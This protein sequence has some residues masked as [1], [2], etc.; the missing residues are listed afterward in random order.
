MEQAL[1]AVAMVVDGGEGGKI[2]VQMETWAQP[3]NKN[4][5]RKM[6]QIKMRYPWGLLSAIG[7]AVP[8]IFNAGEKKYTWCSNNAYLLN[9]SMKGVFVPVLL[10]EIRDIFIIHIQCGA[11]CIEYLQIGNLRWTCFR[12]RF[13]A[14][15]GSALLQRQ[16]AAIVAI[17]VACGEEWF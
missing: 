8:V 5:G 16:M 2:E 14:N 6:K 15:T 13:N 10:M 7:D 1:L 11:S 12:F 17:R 4:N 9:D 3:T